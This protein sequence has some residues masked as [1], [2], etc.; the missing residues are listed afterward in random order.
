MTGGTPDVCTHCGSRVDEPTTLLHDRRGQSYATEP[1]PIE[2]L[3][4]ACY[5]DVLA[6]VTA[7]HPVRVFTADGR[8]RVRID[9]PRE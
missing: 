7:R 6:T 3:C 8:T 1:L 2:R 5:S 9:P 4:P